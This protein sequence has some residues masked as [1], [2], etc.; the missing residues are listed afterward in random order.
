MDIKNLIQAAF[1]A[2]KNSYS[3]YS[4]FKVGAALLA[5]SGV[6]FGG[7]N[8]ENASYSCTNCAEKTAFF[9]AVSG[10]VKKFKAIA[11]V[12]GAGETPDEICAPCGSCRQVMLEFCDYSDFDVI[13]AL[14]EEE[15]EIVKLKDL[16]P[17]PFLPENLE[18]E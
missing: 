13:L 3:P 6:V 2:R 18:T 11:I 10:G 17:Y 7:C 14:N 9:K 15:Y 8:I 4:G 12:G 1:N 16:M 5:E